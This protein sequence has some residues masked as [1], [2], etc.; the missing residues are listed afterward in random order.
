MRLTQR[1]TGKHGALLVVDFQD[2]L[3]AA[4]AGR[5]EVEANVIFLIK[6]RSSLGLPVW[7]TE[8]YPRGLGSTTPAVAELDCRTTRQEHI[9]LLRGSTAPRTTLRP[10]HTPCDGRRHRGTRLRGAD[11]P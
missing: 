5:D 8:Q 6:G 9:P 2:K 10:A 1:L 3:L 7:A 11:R 4:I